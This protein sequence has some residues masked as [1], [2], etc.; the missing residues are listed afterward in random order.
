MQQ[1][2][3]TLFDNLTSRGL[4]LNGDRIRDK[5]LEPIDTFFDFIDYIDK[6]KDDRREKVLKFKEFN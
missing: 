4:L 5:V 6:M 2:M 3:A 1:R